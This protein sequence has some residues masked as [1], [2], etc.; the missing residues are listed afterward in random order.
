MTRC[1][2]ANIKTQSLKAR[3]T[4]FRY[5]ATAGPE[6]FN[7]AEAQEKNLKINYMNMIEILEG[8]MNKSLQETQENTNNWRKC[9]NLLKKTETNGEND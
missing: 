3:A 5:P 1:L 6:Y 2:D 9:I 4:E 8:E 7:I